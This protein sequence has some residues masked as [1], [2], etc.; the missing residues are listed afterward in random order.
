MSWSIV[1]YLKSLID[2]SVV[3]GARTADPRSEEWAWIESV[4]STPCRRGEAPVSTTRH[5]ERQSL[6]TERTTR[7]DDDSARPDSD[8]TMQYAQGTGTMP[9]P[10]VGSNLWRDSRPVS[11]RRYWGPALLTSGAPHESGYWRLARLTACEPSLNTLTVG[12]TGGPRAAK[13]TDDWL[14]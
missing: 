5:D 9:P 7:R 14:G 10:G 2:F 6:V 3:C 12:A 4:P 11:R 13:G 8:T 1:N